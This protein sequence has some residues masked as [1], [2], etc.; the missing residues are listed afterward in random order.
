[1]NGL[2]SVFPQ[3]FLSLKKFASCVEHVLANPGERTIV[4]VITSLL[5]RS[6]QKPLQNMATTQTTAKQQGTLRLRDLV[7][8][9][10]LVVFGHLELIGSGVFLNRVAKNVA[11]RLHSLTGTP[12]L[13]APNVRKRPSHSQL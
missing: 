9:N 11:P 2:Q 7:L 3:K 8:V 6:D 5:Q 4:A 13:T 10:G 12:A 1:M